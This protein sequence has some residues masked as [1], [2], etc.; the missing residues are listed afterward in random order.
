VRGESFSPQRM[1]MPR[2]EGWVYTGQQPGLA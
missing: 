2:I 1:L